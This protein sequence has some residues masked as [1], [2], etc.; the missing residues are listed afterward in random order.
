MESSFYSRQTAIVELR[1]E[2]IMFR[3]GAVKIEETFNRV[4]SKQFAQADV[5]LGWFVISHRYVETGLA[6]RRCHGDWFKIKNKGNGRFVY[7][8]LRFSANLPGSP[9]AENG[10]MVID[11][12]AWLEMSDFAEDV[13]ESMELEV[14]SLGC[15][16]WLR[17]LLKHPDPTHKFANRLA[18]WSFLLAVIALGISLLPFLR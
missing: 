9:K 18:L 14:S 3:K 6:R 5:P 17:A 16:A 12:R 1:A 2:C 13:P 10:D 7:R 11:W 4:S 8:I 15:V